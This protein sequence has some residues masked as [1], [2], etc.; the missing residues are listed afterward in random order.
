MEYRQ[1]GNTDVHVSVFGLGGHEF[2][3]NGSSR[4]FN[5]DQKNAVTP[6]YLFEGFGGEKR[7]KVLACA[8]TARHQSAGCDH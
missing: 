4:G 3:P 5:E 1:I 7:K 8:F 2:L 6:G